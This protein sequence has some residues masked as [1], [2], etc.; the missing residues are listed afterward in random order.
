MREIIFRGKRW[1]NGKWAFGDLNQ[2]QDS[3]IINTYE[4]GCRVAHEVDWRTIGQYT[5]LTSNN[6]QK[7]FEGD[8]VRT[9]YDGYEK[10]L[11]V[12][13][14]DEELD[15]KATNGKKNYGAGGFRYMPCCEEIEVIGNIH[16]NPELLEEKL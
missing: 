14:D 13:W 12:I 7:I 10:I 3:A 6:G 11:V 1:D 15:F 8:I 9:V 4:H 16:D 2:Y 5:G